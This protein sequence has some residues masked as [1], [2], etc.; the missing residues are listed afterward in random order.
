[1]DH[2][3]NHGNPAIGEAMLAAYT[4][5]MATRQAAERPALRHPAGDTAGDLGAL[6]KEKNKADQLERQAA[7]QLQRASLEMLAIQERIARDQKELLL[8]QKKHAEATALKE[9]RSKDAAL[10]DQQLQ[11]AMAHREREL[12]QVAGAPTVPLVP[13]ANFGT[14]PTEEQ[15]RLL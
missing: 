2:Y 4:E 9:E 5:T 8:V 15:A 3:R 14:G 7:A 6:R 11:A 13:E 12:L 10:K 1:M